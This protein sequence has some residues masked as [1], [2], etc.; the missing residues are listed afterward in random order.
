MQ[1]NT[2]RDLGALIKDRRRALKLSQQD[3]AARVGVGRLWIVKLEKGK[4]TAQISL[5][6]RT[7]KELGVPIEASIRPI[8]DTRRADAIDLDAIIQKTKVAR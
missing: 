5:V 7:L 2:S 6:L 4:P 8:G 1:I 3:L